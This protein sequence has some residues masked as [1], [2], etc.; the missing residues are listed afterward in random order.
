MWVLYTVGSLA[1][2]HR[3]AEGCLMD[4]RGTIVILVA[5]APLLK[6]CLFTAGVWW[7][8]KALPFVWR[9]QAVAIEVNR[10]LSRFDRSRMFAKHIYYISNR[11][12]PIDEFNVPSFHF[13]PCIMHHEPFALT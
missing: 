10:G 12:G 8:V 5:E 3:P 7:Y 11:D 2:I 4:A 6:Q 13:G 1:L 9:E